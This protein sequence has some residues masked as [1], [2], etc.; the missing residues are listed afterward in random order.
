MLL[1]TF[2]CLSK[3]QFTISTLDGITLPYDSTLTIRI[4]EV[5]VDFYV[6]LEG[7]ALLEQF[8]GGFKIL[9]FTDA[10]LHLKNKSAYIFVPFSIFFSLSNT[11]TLY[12]CFILHMS[13]LSLGLF[14]PWVELIGEDGMKMIGD[15][16]YIL[17]VISLSFT[18]NT[19]THSFSISISPLPRTS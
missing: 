12:F 10:S 5:G 18:H 14:D 3:Y 7:L 8:Q 6:N 15:V 1:I 17:H 13:D 16:G 11:H 4:N 2:L 19:H 9:W